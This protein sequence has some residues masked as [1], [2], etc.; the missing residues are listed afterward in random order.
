MRAL[1]TVKFGEGFLEK[2]GV[3]LSL[4]EGYDKQTVTEVGQLIYL[5]KTMAQQ[6]GLGKVLKDSE[7]R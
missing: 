1:G 7:G 5:Q 3:E 4:K 2:R 6:L